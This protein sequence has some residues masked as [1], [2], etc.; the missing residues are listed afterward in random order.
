MKTALNPSFALDASGFGSSGD[1][2]V[3][4]VKAQGQFSQPIGRGVFEPANSRTT[5]EF[6]R[7]DK[8]R[9]IERWADPLPF[10]GATLAWSIDE[11]RID[12]GST[13][14][15]VD[16]VTIEPRGWMTVESHMG[17]V[18]ITESGR[19]Q[20]TVRSGQQLSGALQPE[21]IS[22]VE[23]RKPFTVRSVGSE[24]AVLLLARVEALVVSPTGSAITY[25][26]AP[27]HVGF[28]IAIEH[29]GANIF[30]L[31]EASTFQIQAWGVRATQGDHISAYDVD[32]A[33]LLVV[34]NGSLRVD[35]Y[36]GSAIQYEESG[37]YS[38]VD[39]TADVGAGETVSISHEAL[40][41]YHALDRVPVNFWIISFSP[42][43]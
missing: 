23:P 31:L 24:S 12:S 21:H 34:L 42:I 38:P 18:V 26:S 27:N 8:G 17:S 22:I 3:V 25:P 14:F 7:M 5:T 2:V 16:R 40:V 6:L 15:R 20:L 4:M 35:V 30:R 10:G 29:L 28:K 33:E 36:D 1:L 19:A 13:M 9:V 11:I 39:E 37:T 32:G 43:D 41:A